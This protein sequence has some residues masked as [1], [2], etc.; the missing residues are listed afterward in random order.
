MVDFDKLIKERK[1]REIHTYK[2]RKCK[3]EVDYI[4]KLPRH[5]LRHSEWPGCDG[6]IDYVSSRPDEE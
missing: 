2:C 5:M 6:I 3:T 1:P 4:I